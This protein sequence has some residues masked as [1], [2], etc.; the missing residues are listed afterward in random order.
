MGRSSYCAGGGLP[1]TPR[2]PPR[3]AWTP[4]EIEADAARYEA[5]AARIE[6]EAAKRARRKVRTTPEQR[7]RKAAQDEVRIL[8]RLLHE[9]AEAARWGRIV[10]ALDDLGIQADGAKAKADAL[11]EKVKQRTAK[12][13]AKAAAGCLVCADY[14][15][16]DSTDALYCEAFSVP[17]G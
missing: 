10:A 15:A 2:P 12:V 5:M 8:R 13:Y 16:D 4:A 17:A 7:A 9:A 3:P 6:R 11:R 1:P 14:L